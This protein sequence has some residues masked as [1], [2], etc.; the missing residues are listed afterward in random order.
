MRRFIALAT[1]TLAFAHASRGEAQSGPTALEAV[2]GLV[3]RSP[4]A[5]DLSQDGVQAALRIA[6][7]RGRT[8]R[9][10]TG[11]S[12]TRLP[13]QDLI[14]PVYCP[15]PG[16]PCAAGKRTIPGLG[17][18]GT[19]LGLEAVWH[20]AGFELRPSAMGGGYALYHRPTGTPSL[21]LGFDLGLGL[22]LPIGAHERILL[23]GRWVR[24]L[25]EAGDA[26][27]GRRL[28]IG[29]ALH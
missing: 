6:V 4:T 24:L 18:L 26:G 7:R 8:L 29:I 13:D 27:S 2:V 12:W 14:Q 5:Q 20:P 10:L 19:T 1:L 17:M 9:I 22:G 11:V 16:T 15:Q 28:N 3:H 25:G 21:A 23:E